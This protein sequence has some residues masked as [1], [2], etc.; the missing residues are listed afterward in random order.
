MIRR[1]PRSTLFPYTTLFRSAP[2]R[3]LRLVS[4]PAEVRHLRP[5]GLRLG[6]GAHGGVD[7]RPPAHQGGD[8]VSADALQAMAVRPSPRPTSGPAPPDSP[9]PA[10]GPGPPPAAPLPRSAVGTCRWHARGPRAGRSR[11]CARDSRW[12]TTGRRPHLLTFPASRFLFPLRVLRA[13]PSPFGAVPSHPANRT[14]PPPRR[15]EERRVG[16]ECRSRWSP[17]H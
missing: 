3:G 9:V 8:R 5:L 1:P 15:S 2:R 4:R 7:L 6:R 12:R 14:R 10:P 13:P 17:Y 16:K 11:A